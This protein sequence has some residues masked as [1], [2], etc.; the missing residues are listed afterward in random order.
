MSLIYHNFN[1]KLKT[2]RRPESSGRRPVCFATVRRQRGFIAARYPAARCW[3]FLVATASEGSA[4]NIVDSYGAAFFRL[5]AQACSTAQ[6]K[7][8]P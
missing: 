1:C 4:C 3:P 8:I 7:K 5:T 6:D 2:K